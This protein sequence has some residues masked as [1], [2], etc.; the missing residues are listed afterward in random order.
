MAANCAFT[1]QV[2]HLS[3]M[4]LVLAC[5]GFPCLLRHPGSAQIEGP[6]ASGGRSAKRRGASR[7]S[8]GMAQP[9]WRALIRT[10]RCWASLNS[11]AGVCE[12]D[13]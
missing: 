10:S 6:S 12:C 4:H 11:Y 2:L 5:R 1:Q 3:S 7:D 13:L 9:R 8:D